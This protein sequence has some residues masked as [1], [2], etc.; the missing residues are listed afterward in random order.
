MT[1]LD[2]QP[3]KTENQVDEKPLRVNLPPFYKGR[4]IINRS[5]VDLWSDSDYFLVLKP[6]RSECMMLEKSDESSTEK[7][8]GWKTVL[9]D[10]RSC[11]FYDQFTLAIY[12]VTG[13]NNQLTI[14]SFV[15]PT[16]ELLVDVNAPE[17]ETVVYRSV[18]YGYWRKVEHYS[19][20][21]VKLVETGSLIGVEEEDKE[22]ED[23]VEV[24]EAE[25]S[26]C[27]I[28]TRVGDDDG[29][30]CIDCFTQR[31]LI[32]EALVSSLKITHPT[33]EAGDLL[34]LKYKIEYVD[35]QFAEDCPLSTECSDEESDQESD[36]DA[37]PE[38][39][40]QETVTGRRHLSLI[41]PLNHQ[42]IH[43]LELGDQQAKQAALDYLFTKHSF[44]FGPS[45]V[46][47]MAHF[48]IDRQ[49]PSGRMVYSLESMVRRTVLFTKKE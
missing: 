14:E 48:H 3:P 18:G 15:R 29:S 36:E 24:R 34:K 46:G 8:D 49:C 30:V 6:E 31:E 19:A 27:T 35:H 32:R 39:D 44:D 12:T 5:N 37:E 16:G 2:I 42:L 13:Y 20:K 22:D 28:C 7:S 45:C 1:D 23:E 26:V 9:M 41:L 17:G 38:I 21:V 47:Q 33:S 10:N 25:N 43:C 40:E 4:V 11:Y